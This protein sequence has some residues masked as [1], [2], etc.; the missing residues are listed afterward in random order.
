M[1]GEVSCGDAMGKSG[2][3]PVED[4]EEVVVGLLEPLEYRSENW[5]WPGGDM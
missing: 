4:P 1:G 5:S 2:I 3:V